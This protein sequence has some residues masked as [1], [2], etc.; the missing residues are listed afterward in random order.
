MNQ[1]LIWIAG[2]AGAAALVGFG[3]FMQWGKHLELK[4]RVMKVRSGAPDENTTI[5]LLDVRLENL[6]DRT[7]IVSDIAFTVTAKDGREFTGIAVASSDLKRLFEALPALGQGFNPILKSKDRLQPRSTTDR[8]FV[9]QVLDLK[10]A[11]FDE[12]KSAVLRV[13]ELDGAIAEIPIPRMP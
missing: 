10:Q 2:L 5:A 3:L 9:F 1:R 12:R 7:W 8:M 4:T 6:S 13:T 11:A